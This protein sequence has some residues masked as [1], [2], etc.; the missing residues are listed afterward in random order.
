[1]MTNITL[2]HATPPLIWV[3]NTDGLCSHYRQTERLYCQCVLRDRK[4]TLAPYFSTHYNNKG[5]YVLVNMCKIFVFPDRINCLQ[6]EPTIVTN[7]Y[8]CSYI[9]KGILNLKNIKRHWNIGRVKHRFQVVSKFSLET[10]ECMITNY[11]TT[12]R[13]YFNITIL[14]GC[15]ERYNLTF[16]QKYVNLLLD[17][18][19]RFLG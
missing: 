18:K 9:D 13:K 5:S 11:D 17:A 16:T 15:Q 4:L 3:S 7:K 1:M 6:E 2:F 10:S 14:D 19:T 8:N 12:D